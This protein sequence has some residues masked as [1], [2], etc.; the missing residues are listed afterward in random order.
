MKVKAS[1]C[2]I[3]RLTS[4]KL[5]CLAGA[6]VAERLRLSDSY[7]PFPMRLVLIS[8]ATHSLD[9]GLRGLRLPSTAEYLPMSIGIR[10]TMFLDGFCGIKRKDGFCTFTSFCF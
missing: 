3:V 2:M 7:A 1:I 10:D 4:F 9:R 5:V 8:Y 6:I